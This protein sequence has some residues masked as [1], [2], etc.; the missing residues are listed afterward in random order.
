MKKV[1]V[2]SFPS[3]S[4]MEN[5]SFLMLS[6]R[7]CPRT[8]VGERERERETKKDRLLTKLVHNL[9]RSIWFI[10]VSIGAAG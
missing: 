8:L 3:S 9:P 1:C 10:T 2:R 6:N 4:G 7:F 5:G